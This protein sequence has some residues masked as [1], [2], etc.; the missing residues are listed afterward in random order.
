M[1]PD[2]PTLEQIL[3]NGSAELRIHR[4]GMFQR[5][6][7]TVKKVHEPYG[8]YPMLFTDRVID[9]KEAVRIAEELRIPVE[10]PHAKVYPRGKAGNDFV[11]LLKEEKHHAKKQ[12]GGWREEELR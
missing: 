11:H 1:E 12:T 2:E 4:K 3:E 9:L 5:V 7:F 8:T 6:L 10:I